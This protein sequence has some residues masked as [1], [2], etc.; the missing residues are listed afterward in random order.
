MLSEPEG[1]CVSLDFTQVD[2]L[3][4]T[5]SNRTLALSWIS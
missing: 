2:F 4:L 3:L 5:A 1:Q